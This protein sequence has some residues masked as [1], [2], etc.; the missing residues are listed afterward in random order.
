MK[1]Q[2]EIL[3]ATY[4]LHVPLRMQME[5][6]I[7]SQ[8]RR[9]PTLQSSMVGLDTL[10]GRDTQINISDVFGAIS[11]GSAVPRASLAVHGAAFASVG[12]SVRS[13]LTG[14]LGVAGLCRRGARAGR[15]AGR[16][17]RRHGGQARTECCSAVDMSP[18]PTMISPR[19]G[20]HQRSPRFV[21]VMYFVASKRVSTALCGRSDTRAFS[22]TLHIVVGTLAPAIVLACSC[23][24]RATAL[25]KQL[26]VLKV[27]ALL[28][29]R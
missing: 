11:N 1:R 10:A 15:T 27:V 24:P 7:L 4:G 28:E 2:R 23:A 6:E 17:A 5:S 14:P 3:A 29:D 25:G 21:D 22:P 19:H 13:R 8:Y 9:L 20:E 16:F 12:C 18:W 26:V